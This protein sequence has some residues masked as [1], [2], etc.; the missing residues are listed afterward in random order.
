MQPK[1]GPKPFVY[2]QGEDY[3]YSVA[4]I[5]TDSFYRLLIGDGQQ[6]VFTCIVHIQ[7]FFFLPGPNLHGG[8]PFTISPCLS[9]LKMLS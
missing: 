4:L 3:T 9:K 8:T 2:L 5:L 1:G 7:R 6:E